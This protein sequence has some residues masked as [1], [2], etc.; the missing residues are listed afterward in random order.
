[1][2]VICAQRMTLDD[3]NLCSAHNSYLHGRLELA[4]HSA[5]AASTEQRRAMVVDA[6]NKDFSPQLMIG[7]Y[8]Q[9]RIVRVA[10]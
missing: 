2:T 10:L 6:I 5:L 9:A 4:M 1:M 7:C 8:D 3:G